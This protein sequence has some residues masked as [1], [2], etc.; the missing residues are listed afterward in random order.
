M[1]TPGCPRMILGMLLENS[2]AIENTAVIDHV[3]VGYSVIDHGIVEIPL[4][5]EI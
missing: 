2:S 4:V 5:W 3:I 1:R